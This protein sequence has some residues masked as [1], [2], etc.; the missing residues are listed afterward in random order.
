MNLAITRTQICLKKCH[1][2][3]RNW[4]IIKSPNF[5]KHLTC[6]QYFGLVNK[7]SLQESL[8]DLQEIKRLKKTSKQHKFF[9]SEIKS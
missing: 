7:S 1:L 5:N 3:Q 2:R 9:N 6:F 8:F 4:A